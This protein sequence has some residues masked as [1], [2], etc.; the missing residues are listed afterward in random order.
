MVEQQPASTPSSAEA[1]AKP[2]LSSSKTGPS[3]LPG[4]NDFLK[5]KVEWLKAETK[6]A[7]EWVP[8]HLRVDLD[9]GMRLDVERVKELLARGFRPLSVALAAQRTGGRY[10]PLIAAPPASASGEG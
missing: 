7:K 4:V 6:S 2:T 5:S 10:I 3:T 9:E 1:A 8:G